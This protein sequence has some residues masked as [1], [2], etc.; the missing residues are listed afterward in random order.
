MNFLSNHGLL[1]AKI[2]GR[3]G[4][5]ITVYCTHFIVELSGMPGEEDPPRPT[6]VHYSTLHHTMLHDT[7]T[8]YTYTTLEYSYNPDAFTTLRCTTLHGLHAATL[9]TTR[10]F[11]ALH[12]SLQ[13]TL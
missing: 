3:Y 5:P 12:T 13:D 1:W 11:T 8:H 2:V 10:R 7:T 9:R 4:N 6:V